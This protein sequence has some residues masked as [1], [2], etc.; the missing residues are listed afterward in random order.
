[1]RTCGISHVR[2]GSLPCQT[3]ALFVGANLAFGGPTTNKK[4]HVQKVRFSNLSK[5][6]NT[7]RKSRLYIGSNVTLYGQPVNLTPFQDE[8]DGLGILRSIYMEL[9][10]TNIRNIIHI[11]DF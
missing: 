3:C 9:T 8:S 2:F 11:Y 1:M 7:T 10:N 4:E 6:T 5:K